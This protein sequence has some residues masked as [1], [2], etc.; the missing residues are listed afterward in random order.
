MGMLTALLFSRNQSEEDLID[1]YVWSHLAAEYDPIQA[2]TSARALTEKHCSAAQV[3]A[4][5]K[6]IAEWK[7]KWESQSTD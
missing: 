7:K 5:K 3:K 4:A 1:A 6:R 2:A